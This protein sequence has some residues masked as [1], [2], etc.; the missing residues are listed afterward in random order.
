MTVS[1]TDGETAINIGQSAHTALGKQ[2]GWYDTHLKRTID[3]GEFYMYAGFHYYM[4]T[5]GNNRRFL[6]AKTPANL[7]GAKKYQWQNVPGLETHLESV[8]LF[9]LK[10]NPMV[11]QLIK[12]NDLPIVWYEPFRELRNAEQRWLRVVK[13]VVTRLRNELKD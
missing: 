5:S 10:I 1:F 11:L 8:L 3:G 13:R 6:S 7:E 2:L 9:N 4:I 12:S